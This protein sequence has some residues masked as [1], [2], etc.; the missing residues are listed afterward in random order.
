[1]SIDFGNLISRSFEI[2]WKYKTLWIF[3]LFTGAGVHSF[4]ID[5][6][7]EFSQKVGRTF[8]LQDYSPWVDRLDLPSDLGGPLL[9]AIIVWLA[10][11]ILLFF[12]C[13]LI[14]QPAIIDAVN[15]ITRGGQYRLGDSFSRGVDFFW[16]FLGLTLVS[17]MCVLA[18]LAVIVLLAVA[19]LWTLIV[20][21]PCAI[22]VYFFVW[23][24]FALGEVAMVARDGRI[25]DAI[26]EGWDLVWRN[27]TNCLI[28]TFLLIG[29]AIAFMIIMAIVALV[30][31]LPVGLLVALLTGNL[32][33]ILLLGLVIGLPVSMVVG[34]YTGTFFNALYV[35]FYFRLYE[36]AAAPI[37]APVGPTL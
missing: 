24:I 37:P 28:M 36:P 19:S 30:A 4:N 25:A 5:L 3:G 14:A 8:D 35:Q 26:A 27:K 29:I 31:F 12:V 22:I 33:A 16:R 18:V 11:L 6:P 34:G 13:Y 9:G 23:H 1:M 17:I 2:A 10:V 32:I 20:T 21:I 7:D 15:K